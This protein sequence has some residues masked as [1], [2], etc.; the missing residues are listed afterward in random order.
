M[1]EETTSEDPSVIVWP[2]VAVI[3]AG[4]ESVLVSVSRKSH[5]P[6]SMGTRSF[7]LTD[8]SVSLSESY[9]GAG[10]STDPVL[11]PVSARRHNVSGS[12]HTF[13]TDAT[14]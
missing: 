2:S 14:G 1:P 4:S 6:R 3:V 8:R 5:G 11:P 12:R 13:I 10:R 9:S 7:R